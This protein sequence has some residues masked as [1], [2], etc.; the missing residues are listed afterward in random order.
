MPLKLAFR[1]DANSEIGTGHL[2]RCL[3]L[4]ERLSAVG[5]DCYFFC[6][7]LPSA[8]LPLLAPYPDQPLATHD[9]IA[10]IA[11]LRP[12]WL[13]I[14]HYQIGRDLEAR[15]APHCRQLLVIDDLADRVHHCHYLLDQGP[16]RQA[17]DYHDLVPADCRLLLGADFALLRPAYRQLAR[18]QAGAWRKGLICFG[19]ADPAGAS[20]ITLDSLARIASAQDIAWTVVAGPASATRE[21]LETRLADTPQHHITL[22]QHSAEMPQL[23]AEHDFTIGAA[24]GMTWERACIGLPTLA[25]PIVDNQAFN[26]AAIAHYRI[27]VRLSLRELADPACLEAGLRHLHD[28][29]D[30]YRQRGQDLVDGLGLDR[31]ASLILPAADWYLVANG[32]EW[33]LW[34]AWHLKMRLRLSGPILS[35]QAETAADPLLWQ[36]LADC[37]AN[38]L[39]LSSYCLAN[40]PAIVPPA[41]WVADQDRWSLRIGAS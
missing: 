12:D 23:M 14:D 11:A 39:S 35:W 15:L 38:S 32:P 22:L 41:P 16:R 31:L 3:A 30:A 8:L 17:A 28:E 40:P 34:Q 20:L 19:G 2:M 6:H 27:A 13:I 33:Q 1:L 7:D 5:V 9:D 36:K 4:A 26:D 10:P 18:H 37:L 21:A 24:G 25:V 29:A